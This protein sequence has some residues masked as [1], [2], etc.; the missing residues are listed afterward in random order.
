MHTQEVVAIFKTKYYS[1]TY[2]D[3]I[4]SVN[5]RVEQ[6]GCKMKTQQFQ[7]QSNV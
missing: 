4:S 7:L 1:G 3:L 6:A 2:E 5:N